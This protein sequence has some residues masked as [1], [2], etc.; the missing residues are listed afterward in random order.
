MTLHH[1]VIL[2][3]GAAGVAAAREL[4]TNEKV[5]VTLVARTGEVPYTRMLIK[6]IAFSGMPPEM[7]TMVLPDVDLVADSVVTVHADEKSVELASGRRLAFDSLIVATGSTPRLLP[8]DVVSGGA[9]AAEKMTALH[10]I[11]DAARLRDMLAQLEPS[12]R[13]AI[14]GGGIIAAEAATQ[15]RQAKRSVTMIARSSVPG[16]AAFGALVAE[17]LVRLHERHVETRFGRSVTSLRRHGEGLEI[18]LDDG[19]AVSADLLLLALGTVPTG[20]GEWAGGIEVDAHLRADTPGWYAAGGVARHR[21]D[22]L[23][24]WRIDHW[25]DAA[26]QGAH[27][28][29]SVL[30]DLGLEDDPGRYMPRSAFIAMLYGQA[31]AGA[32]L[33][34]GAQARVVD[35]AEFVVEHELAGTLVGVSGID[36]VGTVYSAAPRLHVS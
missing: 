16:A 26:A 31:I 1:V 15:L 28:A 6:G 14:Y 20:V 30:H 21:D 35:G 9:G 18:G 34:G 24:Q 32:G 8:A 5:A 22:Q 36:A 3:A 2:G 25:E 4:S 33:I 23:G 10:S 7:A 13:V 11:D 17:Q 27:A 12:T 19:S 29:R